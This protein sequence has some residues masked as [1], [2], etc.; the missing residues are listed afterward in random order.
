[1][2][3]LCRKERDRK[4]RTS[5]AISQ[6][7]ERERESNLFIKNSVM[8]RR[9]SSIYAKANPVAPSVMAM[10]NFLRKSS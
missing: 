4:E 10:S 3:Q 7:R 2:Q 6:R 5:N 9:A 8:Y 1:L